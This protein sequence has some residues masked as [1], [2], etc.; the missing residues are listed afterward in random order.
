VQ[1]HKTKGYVKKK[2]KMKKINVVSSTT[3]ASGTTVLKEG[4]FIINATLA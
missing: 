2:R 1:V 4:N 3:I